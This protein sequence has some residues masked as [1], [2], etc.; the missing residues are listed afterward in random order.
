MPKTGLFVAIA[1]L[2]VASAPSAGPKHG[3][4]KKLKGRLGSIQ[5][6][7]KAAQA[8]LHATR[9]KAVG[10][11]KT[12]VVVDSR[13]ADVQG[14]L[15]RTTSELGGAREEQGRVAADLV[16][17]QAELKRVREQA[18]VRLRAIAKQ[19]NGNLLAAFAG[20]SS[21]GDLAERN[22]LMARLAR[23]DHALFARVRTLQAGVAARKRRQDALV[24][25]VA[26]L[27]GRQ[28]A[29]QAEL[30]AVRARKGQELVG[31]RQQES[32]LESSLKQ[33]D[34]DAAE[35]NRLIAAAAAAE[36]RRVRSGGAKVPKFTGRYMRPVNAPI[37]SGFGM[38]YHPILHISRLHAGID[39]GASYGTAIHCVAPGVVVAATTMR[40]FGNVVIVDHGGG[41]T[42]VYGHMSRIGVSSGQRV[43]QG[44]VLGAVGASGLATGPHLHF[45]FHIDGRPV[46]PLGHL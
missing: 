42:T 27:A 4:V 31:L 3:S 37:T 28:K 45:E 15:S 36:A 33:F 7:K 25:R 11:K 5:Q 46:N 18:R 29:Q 39:F 2:L 41:I 1:F 30:R 40:G 34:Q 24:V 21:V 14:R 43:G 17:T 10:V 44:T 16:R 35:I 6:Q 26:R 23:K 20:S 22:D 32:E 19:G 13:L 38:R 9:V 8:E 12:I